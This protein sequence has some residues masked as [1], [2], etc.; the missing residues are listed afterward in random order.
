MPEP[1]VCRISQVSTES[2]C[3]RR[4]LGR[5][6]AAKAAIERRAE[7]VGTLRLVYTDDGSSSKSGRGYP[8]LTMTLSGASA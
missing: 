6:A 4:A 5:I 3:E 2:V 1:L 7:C 8:T